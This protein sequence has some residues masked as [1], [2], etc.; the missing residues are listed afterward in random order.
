[1]ST[2]RD[3]FS[4]RS[5]EYAAY[6]PTYPAKLVDFL[7]SVSPDTNLAL[8]CGCGTGQLSV[9]LASR[10]REIVATDASESQIKNAKACS[11]VTYRVARADESGLPEGIVDLITV[12]QAAHWFDLPLFYAEVR[13][14][15]RPAAVM[16][17]ITYGILHIE[18]PGDEII[19]EFYR[20]KLGPYWPPE[21]R[22][23]EDGY[24]SLPFPFLEIEAP[25]LAIEVSWNLF[26]LVGYLGTWSAVRALE[27]QTGSAPLDSLRSELTKAWGDA[28]SRRK[29][30]WPLALRVGRVGEQN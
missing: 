9:L 30:R 7:S 21:R 17:L 23:V 22:H 4:V 28:G 11:G 27:K 10:F 1:M 12:A 18:G 8:D 20:G 5:E 25:P 13:R 6:R 29:V 15:A 19:Q 3:H 16:A 14:V 26:E 24:R 2:F